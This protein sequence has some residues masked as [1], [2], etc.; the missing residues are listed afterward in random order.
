MPEQCSPSKVR[1]RRNWHLNKMRALS[2]TSGQG[3]MSN[4]D[5]PKRFTL[6]GVPHEVVVEIFSYLKA[7]ELV[8]GI[9]CVSTRWFCQAMDNTLWKMLFVSTFGHQD[10]HVHKIAENFTGRHFLAIFKNA[11]EIQ[12][13]KESHP[14]DGFVWTFRCPLSWYDLERT[15]NPKKR[16]CTACKTVIQEYKPAELKRLLDNGR[17]IPPC[18]AVVCVN[19]NVGHVEDVPVAPPIVLL[20]P[21]PKGRKQGGQCKLM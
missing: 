16:V 18:S 20:P 7:N 13:Q 3:F 4:C 5:R 15:S 1:N 21:M 9:L 2:D 10:H 12:R 6:Q 8:H 14:V 17:E 19:A 11:Y